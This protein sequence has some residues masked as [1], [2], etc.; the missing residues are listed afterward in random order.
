MRRSSASASAASASSP[1]ATASS[2]AACM[3]RVF[4]FSAPTHHAS[5]RERL[6]RS[7]SASE[8]ATIASEPAAELVAEPAAEPATPSASASAPP[9]QRR[10][11]AFASFTRGSGSSF[12][13]SWSSCCIFFAN[14]ACSRCSRCSQASHARATA[15]AGSEVAPG[16]PDARRSAST[17]LKAPARRWSCSAQ[18]AGWGHAHGHSRSECV[19]CAGCSFGPCDA[20]GPCAPLLL[21]T[22]PS[23]RSRQRKRREERLA[24]G[25]S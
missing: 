19:G 5:R 23:P 2:Q 9:A 21:P 1:A 22:S 11:R 8:T 4:A 24:W 7:P 3:C 10:R 16:A 12:H 14:S 13:S 18:A 20:G 25:R 6:L 17:S 15:I